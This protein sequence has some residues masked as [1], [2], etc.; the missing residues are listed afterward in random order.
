MITTEKRSAATGL[1]SPLAHMIMKHDEILPLIEKPGILA[2]FSRLESPGQ[3]SI[4]SN[5]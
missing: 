4:D 2:L 5:G 3:G 1:S